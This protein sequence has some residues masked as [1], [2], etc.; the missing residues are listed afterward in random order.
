MD[1]PSDPGASSQRDLRRTT[2]EESVSSSPPRPQHPNQ[3]YP[4]SAFLSPISERTNELNDT[5]DSFTHMDSTESGVDVSGEALNSVLFGEDAAAR[6]T[7]PSNAALASS[8]PV[9]PSIPPPV[10]AEAPFFSASASALPYGVPPVPP[11]ILQSPIATVEDAEDNDDARPGSGESHRSVYRYTAERTQE[12]SASPVNTHSAEEDEDEDRAVRRSSQQQQQQQQVTTSTSTP[13]ASSSSLSAARSTAVSATS[14]TRALPASGPFSFSSSSFSSSSSAATSSTASTASRGPSISTSFLIIEPAELLFNDV[15]EKKPYAQFVRL[16]NPS[17]ILPVSFT[18]RPGS[19][20]RFTVSP[21]S[22]TLTPS[23]STLVEVR[24]LLPAP[25][26]VKTTAGMLKSTQ[27]DVFYIKG[28]HFECRFHALIVPK[29]SSA[30]TIAATAAT[31]AGASLGSSSAVQVSAPSASRP[32]PTAAPTSASIPIP[33]PNS[34]VSHLHSATIED[35]IVDA[36]L[37]NFASSHASY[38]GLTDNEDQDYEASYEEGLHDVVT[39]TEPTITVPVT[40][41]RTRIAEEVRS[42]TAAAISH[43]RNAQE[44]RNSKGAY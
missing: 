18:I 28:E 34:S 9:P 17:V 11:V 25:L 19:P 5:R 10:A 22:I 23:Q 13:T 27:R 12:N 6:E 1:A 37:L 8:L 30:I 32:K 33:A 35:S 31:A 15:V 2:D 38:T 40:Q 26:A 21:H 4:I 44:E 7:G 41:L 16:T 42:A 36:S 3:G 29:T 43:E 24:L 14:A 20:G 39:T